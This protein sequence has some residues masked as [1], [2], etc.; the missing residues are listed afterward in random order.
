MYK[1]MTYELVFSKH[2]TLKDAERQ[3]AMAITDTESD[4]RAMEEEIAEQRD[5]IANLTIKTD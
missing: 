2:E 1:V 5:F 4:I 3:M